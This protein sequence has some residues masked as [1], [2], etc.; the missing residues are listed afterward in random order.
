[1]P[2]RKIL[3]IY[4]T[5]VSLSLNAQVPIDNWTFH[6]A[7]DSLNISE[8]TLPHTWNSEDA[9]DDEPGY[10]RGRGIYETSFGIRDKSAIH[11]LHF[12][13]ANQV[14]TVYVNNKWAGEHH[15]GYTA[16]DIPI[17]ELIHNG[18]NK[19]KVV[20]DNSH[21]EQVPP[22]DADFTF[23]GGI[24]RMVYLY[25]ENELSFKRKA[26]ADQVY[27]NTLVRPE[28]EGVIKIDVGINSNFSQEGDLVSRIYDNKGKL[29]NSEKL[30]LVLNEQGTVKTIQLKIPKVQLW[31]PGNPYLYRVQLKLL[32]KNGITTDVYEHRVG[33][34]TVEA[35]PEGFLINGDTLKLIG[36]NRH[37][38]LAGFGNAVPVEDQLED[39]RMIKALGSNFL[40]L[41]HYPQ[42]PEIYKAADS[43]GLILWSEIP[44]VNK[45]PVG[46]DY[47]AYRS[48]VLQMQEEHILQNINHPALVF[49]GY[50][51][52]I[53]IRLIFDKHSPEEEKIIKHKSLELAEELEKLTRQLAPDH[54]TVMAIHGHQVYNETGIT[55]LPMVL[56]WNLYY[57]WYLGENEDLGEFLDSEHKKFPGR[58]LILSEYGVGSD[59][60]LH[61]ENPRKYDFTEEYQLLHHQAYLKQI[62]ERPYMIGM[63]VWNFSDF[64]SEFRGDTRPHINQ[65][66]LVSYDRSPKNIY[67]WYKAMLNP[68]DA[69]IKIY[70]DNLPPTGPENQ[71][72]IRV[73]SNR[74]T[75]LKIN[76]KYIGMVDPVD[77]IAEFRSGLAPGINR[78]QAFHEDHTLTDLDTLH[79]APAPLTRIGD[80]M[81]WNLGAD[82]Y[83]TDS[84]EETWHPI[85]RSDDMVQL[86]GE[87]IKKHTAS[88]IRKTTNDPI[89]QSA[90]TGIES[91]HLKLPPGTY[92]ISLH[93]AL[94][95]KPQ[96]NIYELGKKQGK[97]IGEVA[98]LLMITSDGQSVEFKNPEP[99]TK[100]VSYMEYEQK[101]APLIIRSK[102]DE[103]L[104]LNGIGVERIR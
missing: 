78:L 60:R 63:A 86:K 44:V 94:H 56:G 75:G 29:L 101:S 37:Q 90:I 55:D 87:L 47:E 25:A 104:I 82:S 28:G 6:R 66:G 84:D 19:L 20:V 53:F 73:I 41:A 7:G 91:I 10:Y 89:Y 77:G 103:K 81:H 8:V 32:D 96:E 71:K 67:W 85:M 45:V 43:L 54:I 34:R 74:R 11:Y 21:D 40:R 3:G 61:S 100:Y 62:K 93:Y 65:K 50:M 31:S 17:S 18:E 48:N 59:T 16:F 9:F 64:G 68:E 33:F 80:T 69:F 97:H 13:G 102:S 27:L 51:N 49:I 23:Y 1:M 70:R 2:L 30:S 14:T 46:E 99:L 79:Y 4:I 57:G 88:N 36:V 12:Q 15:G 95:R 38:D 24:Y 83:F 58:P 92:R 52:E 22:L 26:G 76:E 72:V 42:Q 39:L 98:R 35:T 5:L